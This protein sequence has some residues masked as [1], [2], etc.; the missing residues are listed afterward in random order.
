M[1][2][3][4]LM[5]HKCDIYHY[6]SS[7]QSIGYGFKEKKHSY[8]DVADI[9]EVSCHFHATESTI[10]QDETMNKYPA[11][12]K[13]DFPIGTNIQLNDKVVWSENGLAYTAEIPRTIRGHHIV[14]YVNRSGAVKEAL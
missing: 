3:E 2:I 4:D 13:V 5:D 9:K 14:V 11:H 8:P 6:G 7:D 10:N 1:S 12:I